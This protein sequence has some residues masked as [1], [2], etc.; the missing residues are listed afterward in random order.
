MGTPLITD[1]GSGAITPY[2]KPQPPPA[3]GVAQS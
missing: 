1:P 3:G 2:T